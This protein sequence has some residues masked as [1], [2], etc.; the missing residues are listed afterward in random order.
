[1][2]AEQL[3]RRFSVIAQT[4]L[5]H[6]AAIGDAN[7]QWLHNRLEH[8]DWQPRDVVRLREMMLISLRWLLT[9]GVAE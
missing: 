2:S 6:H 5:C 8:G 3:L 9:A 4:L 7:A 1:M